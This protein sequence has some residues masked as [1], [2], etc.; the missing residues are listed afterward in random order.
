MVDQ[1]DELLWRLKQT[2]RDKDALD[3][4]FLQSLLGKKQQP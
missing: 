4:V 1:D 3:R 2:L